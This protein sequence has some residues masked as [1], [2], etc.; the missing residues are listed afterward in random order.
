M[1]YDLKDFKQLTLSQHYSKNERSELTFDRLVFDELLPKPTID[2]LLLYNQNIVPSDT[3]Q[4]LYYEGLI[5][6]MIMYDYIYSFNF[7]EIQVDRGDV[8]V[9]TYIKKD[10][11]VEL[12]NIRTGFKSVYYNNSEIEPEFA[13]QQQVLHLGIDT[14]FKYIQ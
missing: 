11:A 1:I 14:V 12:A 3:F 6:Y 2:Y 4:V 8:K 7:D 5:D 13:F 9:V 10:T